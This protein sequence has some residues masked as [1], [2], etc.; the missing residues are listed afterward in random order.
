MANLTGHEDYD[1]VE[2]NEVDPDADNDADGVPDTAD[3]GD[4]ADIDEDGDI[5]DIDE[6]G[7]ADGHPGA[8]TGT[9]PV[10]AARRETGCIKK[11][12]IPN[13]QRITSDILTKFEYARVL[14]IRAT[15]ISKGMT[16]FTDYK[17]L[18]KEKD[19]AL[20]ELNEGKCPLI[21]NRV[22]KETPYE[23]YIE[24]WK[25]REMILPNITIP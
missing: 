2:M 10:K 5:I 23:V 22:I 14:A 13:D 11:I 8:D 15:H 24:Q 12:I 9:D 16:V 18:F 25:V 20:K 19:I 6:D 4:A 3:I 1:D 7:D 17:G 21:I